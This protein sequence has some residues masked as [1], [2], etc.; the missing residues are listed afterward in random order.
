MSN[1]IFYG[2]MKPMNLDHFMTVELD[3]RHIR[4]IPFDPNQYAS[5]WRFGHP[6]EARVIYEKIKSTFMKELE[7]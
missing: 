7:L 1:F 4:F 6:D 2:D 5:K 3:E